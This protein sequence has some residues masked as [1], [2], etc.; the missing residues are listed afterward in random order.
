MSDRQK[1]LNEV[2]EHLRSHFGIHT[3]IDFANA[4]RYS[5]A[6]ISSALN[7]NEDNLTDKLFRNVCAAYPGVFNLD[8]LLNGTG[9]LLTVE[10]DIKSSEIENNYHPAIPEYVQEL[11]DQTVKVSVRCEL[12]EQQLSFVLA[13][14]KELR[15]KLKESISLVEKLTQQL[16]ATLS[17]FNTQSDVDRYLSMR[18]NEPL[19]APIPDAK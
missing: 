6:V 19:N 1:R 12:L 5:R 14:N 18:V 15:T 10:E 4:L 8:Y 17:L 2:Y 11:I 7:G 13:D 9:S 3:Q 16:S